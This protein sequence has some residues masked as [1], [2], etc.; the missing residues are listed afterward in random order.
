MESFSLED[1]REYLR[2]VR[3]ETRVKAKEEPIRNRFLQTALTEVFQEHD[4]PFNEE[5]ATLQASEDEDTLGWFEAPEDFSMANDWSLTIG[6]TVYSKEKVAWKPYLDRATG[7]IWFRNVS[8]DSATLDYFI[9]A[10]DLMSDPQTE[11]YFPQ[12]M[13]IAERGYVRLKTAYFPDESS[14]N[15]LKLNK[16]A[17]RSLYTDMI[18]LPSFEPRYRR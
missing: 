8:G 3:G 6:T 5:F 16:K 13:L 11:A 18:P 14:E 9:K 1:L 12:P 15:E 7:K 2:A 17:L 10:P 4:W